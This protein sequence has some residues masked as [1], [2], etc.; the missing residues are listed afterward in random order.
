ML[1]QTYPG[2][3]EVTPMKRR[4]IDRMLVEIVHRLHRKGYIYLQNWRSH[5]E[6]FTMSESKNSVSTQAHL[7]THF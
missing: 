6:I 1:T 7:S 4:K 2:H 3:S 5:G